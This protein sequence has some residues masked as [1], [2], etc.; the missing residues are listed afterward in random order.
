MCRALMHLYFTSNQ[1]SARGRRRI[2]G[3]A[4]V[5]GTREASLGLREEEMEVLGGGLGGREAAGR[6]FIG[7]SDGSRTNCIDE[8]R[9]GGGR[10]CK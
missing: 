5:G 8:V 10:T 7:N 4:L 6:G 3:V 1:A 9:G 2:G